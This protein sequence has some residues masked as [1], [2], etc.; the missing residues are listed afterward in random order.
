MYG[1]KTFKEMLLITYLSAIHAPKACG[2]ET[3]QENYNENWL[4]YTGLFGVKH[5]TATLTVGGWWFF[6]SDF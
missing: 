4:S 3:E 2:N 5:C 6:P 1:V